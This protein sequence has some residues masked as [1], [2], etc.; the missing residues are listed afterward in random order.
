[1]EMRTG[2]ENGVLTLCLRSISD[3][4]DIVG[5]EMFTN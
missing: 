1:M 5:D 4:T 2:Y 3:G